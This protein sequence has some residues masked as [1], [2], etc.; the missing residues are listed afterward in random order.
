MVLR[1]HQLLGILFLTILGVT[2]FTTSA[3][4]DDAIVN[5]DTLNVRE[6]PGTHYDRIGQVHRS[7]SYHIVDEK[8][9]WVKIQWNT[10]TAWVAKWL[11]QVKQSE[12]IKS[13]YN[14]LR[15]RTEP[16]TNSK[17]L[18]HLMKG[19]QA[20]V[21]SQKGDWL[22]INRN[23]LNGWVHGDYTS[24]ISQNT[25]EQSQPTHA[26]YS[27]TVIVDVPVLNVRNSGSLSGKVID[28]VHSGDELRYLEK[29]NDWYQVK[30]SD[31]DTG[32]IAGWLTKKADSQTGSTSQY[33]VLNYDGTNLRSGPSTSYSILDR[34]HKGDRFRVL[35]KEGSWYKIQNGSDT[36][37]VAGWIVTP[38][39]GSSTPAKGKLSNKIIILDAGHGGRDS[40]AIGA[41]GSYEK[42]I[43]LDTA[44]RVKAY[45]KAAGAKVIMTRSNDTYVSLFG[46]TSLSNSSNAD[47]FISLHYNSFPPSPSAR[48]LNTFYAESGDR[49]LAAN[50]QRGLVRATGL[51][52]RGA[53]QSDYHVIRNNN[54]PAVLLELGFLSNTKEEQLVKTS[55]YQNQ[56]AEGIVNGLNNYF[57]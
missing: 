31:G 10:R 19:D 30:L 44:F 9:N 50:L 28:Q 46:R 56:V 35:A 32:W 4:A 18:S 29:Q 51:R 1:L 52:D 40:G 47:V 21:V 23:G 49:S 41:R 33:V 22:K 12:M 39:N 6:G 34:A 48:G 57:K 45:L 15:I 20:K 13:D 37:Y 36:A 26:S 53:K 24:T 43:T 8:Q 7:E 38:S 11:V 3:Y 55:S 42:H 27:G 25:S 5:V 14:Y 17:I 16:N 54:K 2:A